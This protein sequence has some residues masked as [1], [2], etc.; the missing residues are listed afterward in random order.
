MSIEFVDP[1]LRRGTSEIALSA[2]LIEHSTL[3][4]SLNALSLTL[5]FLDVKIRP[6]PELLRDEG[7]LKKPYHGR[8]L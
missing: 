6:V 7:E 8:R 5:R 4:L 3:N 2:L 1:H